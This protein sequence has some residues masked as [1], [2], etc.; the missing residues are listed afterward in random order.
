MIWQAFL[1]GAPVIVVAALLTAAL[2]R[3]SAAIRHHIWASALLVQLALLPLIP[4]MPTFSLPFPA[5]PPDFPTFSPFG[6]AT[7][8]SRATTASAQNVSPK[9]SAPSPHIRRDAPG[10]WRR[11]LLY[12]WAVGAGLIF[13]RYV[14]GTLMMARLAQ[15]GRRVD[16]GEWLTLAQRIARELAITRPVTLLWGDKLA[17][18]ITWGIL[19]PMILLPGKAEEWSAERRRFVLLHELAHVRRFDA[20]TQLVAQLTLAIFWFSPFVWLCEWRLR[21]EREHACDDVVLQHGTEPTTYADELLQIVRS[22]ISRKSARPAFAALAMAR[23]SEFEGRML[24]ILD[25][26]RARR[27]SGVGSALLFIA[28]SLSI[29]APLAAVNPYPHDELAA[30]ISPPVTSKGAGASANPPEVAWDNC[31]FRQ[32]QTAVHSTIDKQQ[33]IDM[34][35][36][37]EAESKCSWL[38]ADGGITF[39]DDDQYVE[40]MLPGSSVLLR[41]VTRTEDRKARLT[42]ADN[43]KVTTIY[44]VNGRDADPAEAR[45][46]IAHVMPQL[47]RESG[48]NADVR[49]RVLLSAYGL[50]GTLARIESITSS[51]RTTHY[52]ALL[53]ARK[54]SMEEFGEIGSSQSRP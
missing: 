28:L 22:L 32:I 54:W 5:A 44:T 41:E 20:L 10:D 21:V 26:T 17:V 38:M 16:E 50:R 36:K 4:V 2:S 18:P 12:L 53:R 24:A 49:V 51:S 45:T 52:Q 37:V 47:L 35:I 1:R 43:G 29:A 27:V 3:R 11:R 48:D 40:A 34:K 31:S 6:N 19:Y 9:T 23:R 13:L 42:P 30:R 25:P 7:T 39:R 15:R 8:P 14:I 46:W 33:R